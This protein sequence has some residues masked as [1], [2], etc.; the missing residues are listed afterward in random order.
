MKEIQTSKS[1]YNGLSLLTEEDKLIYSVGI[2]TGGVAELRM[3]RDE[4]SRHI[5][6]T[7]VDALGIKE[8]NEYI[9][10]EGYDKQIE[11][12]LEDVSKAL[13]YKNGYFDFIYARLV[14]HY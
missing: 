11:I 10:N 4:P 12:K 3:A 2:S 13:P 14:L 9:H 8:A 1:E 7:T 6:A 5:I